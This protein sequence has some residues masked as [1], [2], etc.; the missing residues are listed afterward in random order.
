MANM[1]SAERIHLIRQVYLS[2]GEAIMALKESDRLKETVQRLEKQ[3]K[4]RDQK[5]VELLTIIKG[6]ETISERQVQICP[7]C[8]GAGA[9]VINNEVEECDKCD[10]NGWI[11]KK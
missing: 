4:E 3:V 8:L 6:L 9:Y 1:T 7:E 2:I 10:T 11:E 5:I